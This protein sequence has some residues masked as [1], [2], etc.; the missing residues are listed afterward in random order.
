[1]PSL[2]SFQCSDCANLGALLGLGNATPEPPLQ[3]RRRLI[4]ITNL[5]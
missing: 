1:M 5:P 3:T 2:S 4:A